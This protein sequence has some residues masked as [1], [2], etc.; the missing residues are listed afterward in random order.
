MA[1]NNMNHYSSL[2]TEL[3]KDQK[4][5]GS[6]PK[7]LFCASRYNQFCGDRIIFSGITKNDIV[8]KIRFEAVGCMLSIASAS[9]LAAYI[10]QKDCVHLAS[11]TGETLQ[12]ALSIEVGPTR[13]SCLLLPVEALKLALE[14]KNDAP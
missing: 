12:K 10:D 2:I 4:Y 8:T 13:L 5:R 6:V 9:F 1:N 7:A 14:R 11:I 3:A